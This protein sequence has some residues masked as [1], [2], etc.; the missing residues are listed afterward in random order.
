MLTVSLE[1]AEA[2]RLLHLAWLG[3]REDTPEHSSTMDKADKKI[4]ED[5]R[6]ECESAKGGR[7]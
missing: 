6:A 5:F 2:K 4:L 3:L 7:L 1:S